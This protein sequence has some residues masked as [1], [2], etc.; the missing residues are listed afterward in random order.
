[1]IEFKQNVELLI[2]TNYFLNAAP[3]WFSPDTQRA[4]M[5][6]SH[7][8]DAVAVAGSCASSVREQGNQDDDRDRNSDQP[9]KDR[10]HKVLRK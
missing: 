10:A 5:K 4:M 1:M 9:Q 7:R 8:S 3:L 2:I 6:K